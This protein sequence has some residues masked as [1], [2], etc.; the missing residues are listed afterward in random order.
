VPYR[1]RHSSSTSARTNPTHGGAPEERTL[2]SSRTLR[3]DRFARLA[4]SVLIGVWFGGILVVALAVPR[5]FATVDQVMADPAPEAVKAI[6][7]IG[8]IRARLLLRYQVSEANR[9]MLSLWGW[10][11]L[12]LALAV[13][14]IT[15][16][17]TKAQRLAVALAGAMLLIALVTNFLLVPRLEQI[18][19]GSD[20]A[21]ALSAGP[22]SDRFMVLHRG[23]TA[24]EA[25]VGI[26]GAVLLGML[27]RQAGSRRISAPSRSEAY[28]GLGDKLN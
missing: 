19:R 8:P 1:R 23:F 4:L 22:Q 14:G 26:L 5:S 20:F 25:V 9:A 16:F 2:L 12:A 10:A 27:F 24:F 7:D 18:S 28:P 17:G 3:S 11:Q 6:R 15:L 13:F 21:P